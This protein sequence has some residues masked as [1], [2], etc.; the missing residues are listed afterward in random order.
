MNA[1]RNIVAIECARIRVRVQLVAK[2]VTAVDENY[3][4]VEVNVENTR[5]LVARVTTT[6]VTHAATTMAVVYGAVAMSVLYRALEGSV[7]RMMTVG[8]RPGPHTHP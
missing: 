8:T 7:R 6:V 2:K 3:G 4:V 1:V 5:V